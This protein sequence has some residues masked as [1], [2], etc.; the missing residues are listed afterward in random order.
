M[1]EDRPQWGSLR[2]GRK[3]LHAGPSSDLV[4]PSSK[5]L[6][7]IVAC[8]SVLPPLPQGSLQ[9]S[10]RPSHSRVPSKQSPGCVADEDGA[11]PAE[12]EA[13]A[14]AAVASSR[15]TPTLQAATGAAGDK[16]KGGLAPLRRSMRST[17]TPSAPRGSWAPGSSAD[18]AKMLSG[19]RL[20]PSKSSSP[21]DFKAGFLE[22][23]SSIFADTRASWPVQPSPGEKSQKLLE[24][25]NDLRWTAANGV[26]TPDISLG[27]TA[28]VVNDLGDCESRL[29]Q[30]ERELLEKSTGLAADGAS[31]HASVLVS[32]RTLQCAR[33]KAE[34]LKEVEKELSKFETEFA[35]RDNLLLLV[36]A[37]DVLVPPVLAGALKFVASFTHGPE[38][39]PSEAA[40]RDE[41]E[42]F[43]KT[44]KLPGKHHFLESYRKQ[45]FEA[46]EWWIESFLK[47]DAYGQA[48]H[49]V[50][51]RIYDVARAAGLPDDHPKILTAERL[52]KVYPLAWVLTEAQRELEVD[53]DNVKKDPDMS[54]GIQVLG[55]ATDAAA[56]IEQN[57][58]EAK[59][60]GISEGDP[61]MAEATSIMKELRQR[62]AGR[63]RLVARARRSI[64]NATTA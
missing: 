12:A 15:S 47:E 29:R 39:K 64:S 34:L 6:P 59:E 62:D 52:L 48:V 46:G 4:S 56:R 38:D 20:S 58:M 17:S 63:K 57:V 11:Q 41:F 14:Q 49:P 40:A 27:T 28:A 50:L 21:K 8:G 18:T 19:G 51:K 54:C 45:I 1:L 9:A 5:E 53:D 23:T 10:P 16:R 7:G 26:E 55:A 2:P 35:D 30:L 25:L 31:R 42:V 33:R 44:F 13:G 36:K 3:S 61:Q 37:G 43:V 22:S 60:K 32:Q 24:G